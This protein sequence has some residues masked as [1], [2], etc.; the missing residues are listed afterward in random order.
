MKKPHRRLP[1]EWEQHHSILLS[2]PHNGKDW[3]GKFDTA[4]WALIDFIKKVTRF[5][6]LLLLVKNANHLI[7]VK[8]LLERHHVDYSN[9]QFIF[10]ET[11]RSWMRDSGP[12]I[13]KKKDG[14]SEALKFK[15]NGWA[16]YA[17]FKKDRFVPDTISDF[18][19]IPLTEVYHRDRHVVLEG[20]AIDVNGRGTLITTEECLLDSQT[21]VRNKHFS[22]ADY[23]TIFNEYL[24]VTNVIWLKNGIV[25]DDTH[26]HVDDICRFV[27]PNT[28]VACVEKD[29]NDPNHFILNENLKILKNA[30]L[31]NGSSLNVIEIPMP[32][33]VFFEEMRLPASYVNF[34][35]L[36]DAVLFPT[37]NDDNDKR[38]YLIFQTIFPGREVIGIHALDMVWGLGT[39]HCLSHEI[40]V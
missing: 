35:I 17:N 13:V 38:A 21:Q 8:N 28:V 14:T 5:E 27:N 2:F 11:N 30:R 26:G 19:N 16:K 24:G 4:K 33:P 1:A 39:L 10:L 7:T 23:Q 36:N 34:L 37:F 12:I 9:I 22:K 29:I 40:P 31:E 3:P 32:K 20:G 6:K 25:G 15:F 18:L